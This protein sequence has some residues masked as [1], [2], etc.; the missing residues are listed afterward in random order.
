M[1]RIRYCPDRHRNY[2]RAGRRAQA[3]HE[4]RMAS[5]FRPQ[6]PSNCL[7][8]AEDMNFGTFELNDTTDQQTTSDILVRCTNGTGYSVAL[9]TGSG[10]YTNRELLNGSDKLLYNLYT[11]ATYSVVWGDDTGD[12]DKVSGLGTGMGIANLQ[13]LK[14]HGRILGSEN[15]GAKPGAYTSNIVAT[16]TY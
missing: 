16:I 12:T 15:L 7:I 4:E 3:A 14:V 6:S 2:A 10:S 11:N 8:S 9:S 13:T 1:K 5:L